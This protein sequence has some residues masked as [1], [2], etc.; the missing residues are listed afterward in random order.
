MIHISP[1]S[2]TLGLFS[3]ASQL[4]KPAGLLITYGPYSVNGVLTPESNVNFNRYLQSENPEWGVRDVRD[5]TEVGKKNSLKFQR[6]IDM[7][8]NNKILIFKKE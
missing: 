6:S 5:L 8:A 7:P 2:C 3:V 1:W 4:L